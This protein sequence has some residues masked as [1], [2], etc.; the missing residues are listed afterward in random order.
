MTSWKLI[1][2]IT[3]EAQT[4]TS[5][6]SFLIGQKKGCPKYVPKKT[7]EGIKTWGI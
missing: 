7:P 4:R 5:P 6:L 3:T 2:L 1:G